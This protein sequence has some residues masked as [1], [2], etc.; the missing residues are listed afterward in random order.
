LNLLFL[1]HAHNGVDKLFAIEKGSQ[2]NLVD[3]GAGS[4]AHRVAHELGDR[5]RL[6]A[7]VRSISQ[8]DTRVVVTSDPVTVTAGAVVVSVPPALALDIAF[9]PALPTDRETLYRNAIAGPESKTLIV[10][11][12][13]FW[14]G[15]GLSGQSAHPGS[16][17][18]VT[19]DAS[20]ADGRAGVL[21][22]FT[23]SHVAERF[24]ALDPDE[25]RRVMLDELT[26]RFGSRASSP[27]ELIHTAWWNEPYTRGCSMAHFRPGVLTRYGHLL[28]EPFGRVHW[29]GTETATTSY[30]AID[31]AIRSGERAAAELL[32][33][34]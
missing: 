11:D 8:T 27:T 30:G 33:R 26:A 23:F 28:R 24:D 22:S 29:A 32:D 7:P 15:D 17:S 14:R 5:V 1:A 16:A 13:P 4:I 2:E 3:G 25:R 31:G 21:A 6:A 20:P 19:I 10:Y 34:A 18:E 9:D 12:E